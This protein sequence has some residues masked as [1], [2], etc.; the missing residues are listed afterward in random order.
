MKWKRLLRQHGA[1]RS[2]CFTASTVR[3]EKLNICATVSILQL[4]LLFLK[5]TT[6]GLCDARILT[7]LIIVLRAAG[8]AASGWMDGKEKAVR[9][10][11][12]RENWFI[13]RV[14]NLWQK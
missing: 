11:A 14:N 6:W 9:E 13:T 10:P 1:Q 5:G 7:Y 2:E 12:E 8:L 4:C 3:R